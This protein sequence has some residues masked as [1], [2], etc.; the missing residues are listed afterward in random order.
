MTDCL[1]RHQTNQGDSWTYNAG[2]DVLGWQAIASCS[3][4]GSVLV[5]VGVTIGS[6]PWCSV[7]KST[8]YGFSWTKIN[9]VSGYFTWNTVTCSQDGQKIVIGGGSATR[10][11][12]NGGANW[13]T[14]SETVTSTGAVWSRFQAV[15][16]N[17]NKILGVAGGSDGTTRGIYTSVDLGATWNLTS[18]S[19]EAYWNGGGISADGQTIVACALNDHVYMSNDGG[20]TYRMVL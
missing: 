13:T 3:S 16:D 12:T 4:N 8:N 11:S 2:T 19:W 20:G 9:E 18:G 10:Y 1:E 14:S 15:D 7:Y 17:L 6:D 5:G